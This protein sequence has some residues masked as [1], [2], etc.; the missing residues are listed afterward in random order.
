M[1]D[2][3][4]MNK[5]LTADEAAT[6][7]SILVGEA[8]ARAAYIAQAP[9]GKQEELRAEVFGLTLAARDAWYRRHFGEER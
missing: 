4:D 5:E 9:Q 2:I 3:I 7:Q 1:L 8:V 6:L